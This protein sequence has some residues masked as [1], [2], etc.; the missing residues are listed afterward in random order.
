MRQ[1]IN[2]KIV[3]YLLRY[4][5]KR[6]GVFGSFARGEDKP[7]SDIDI[8]VDFSGKI[9]LFDLGGIKY[10]L[11]LLLK[12]PVDIVTERGLNSRLRDSVKKDLK[13]IYGQ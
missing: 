6:I 9:T 3:E 5:P 12:R 11:S 4:N 7:S 8:L 10:D 1:Y 2:D 13:I